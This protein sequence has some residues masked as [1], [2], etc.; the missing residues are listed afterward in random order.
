MEHLNELFCEK[1]QNSDPEI[2]NT[3]HLSQCR[4]DSSVMLGEKKIGAWAKSSGGVVISQKVM[5]RETVQ[6]ADISRRVR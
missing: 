2:A 3:P 5:H 1:K 6:R 4:A